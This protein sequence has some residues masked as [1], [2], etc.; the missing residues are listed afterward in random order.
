M[1]E[2]TS[3]LPCGGQEAR[4]SLCGSIFVISLTLFSVF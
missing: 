3:T 1:G 4:L 2:F